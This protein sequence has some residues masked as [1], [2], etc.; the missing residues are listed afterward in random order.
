VDIFKRK[1]K[2]ITEALSQLSDPS[3]LSAEARQRAKKLEAE[4]ED[5]KK[6]KGKK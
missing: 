4:R 1:E 3:S 2:I 6:G 5:K